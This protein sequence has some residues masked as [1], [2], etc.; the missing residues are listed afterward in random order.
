LLGPSRQ[1]PHSPGRYALYREAQ[2]PQRADAARTGSEALTQQQQAMDLAIKRRWPTRHSCP[3]DP[4][5]QLEDSIAEM[6]K[7]IAE[8]NADPEYRAAVDQ[9]AAANARQEDQ[10]H[11]QQLALFNTELPEDVN[12]IIARRLRH[13][14]LA[15]SDVDFD[16]KLEMRE[17]EKLRFAN[18]ACE[19]RS[20]D[21]KMCFRAG[22]PPWMPREPR[23]TSGSRLAP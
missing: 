21:W 12:V 7:Q 11:A 19:H 3:P 6:R 5:K 10:D 22:Y 17:D 16:A 2:K 15:C 23:P 13:F 9:M 18:P 1:A 14:L 4:Q 20:A 8:L